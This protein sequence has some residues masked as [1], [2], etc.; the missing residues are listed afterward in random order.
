LHNI[1]EYVWVI[2]EKIV[3]LLV[4]SNEY[5]MKNQFLESWISHCYPYVGVIQA[6]VFIIEIYSTRQKHVVLL[7][8]IFSLYLPFTITL[9]S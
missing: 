6:T 5:M 4:S 1:L 3:S 9:T 2:R 7:K 8:D